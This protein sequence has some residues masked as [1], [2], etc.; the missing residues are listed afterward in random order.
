MFDYFAGKS[1]AKRPGRFQRLL[2]LS[3]QTS[4]VKGLGNNRKA[5]KGAGDFSGII[6]AR[7]IIVIN[8]QNYGKPRAPLAG[9]RNE[10]A[11][12]TDRAIANDG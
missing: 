10:I 12:V 9:S 7:K 3:Q 8:C 1:L 2:D 4:Q 6:W 11:M 5:S